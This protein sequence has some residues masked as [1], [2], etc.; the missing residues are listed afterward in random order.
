MKNKLLALASG[1]PQPG[2]NGDGNASGANQEGVGLEAPP[3]VRPQMGTNAKP[4]YP[5]DHV[6]AMQVPRG[7]S[8]C[9]NCKYLAPD[10][11]NC[12]E[13]N[14]IRWNGGPQ[15]PAPADSYRSDWYMPNPAPGGENGFRQV[16]RPGQIGGMTKGSQPA[17]GG[18]NSPLQ[19]PGTGMNAPG[20]V[21]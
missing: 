10:G 15:L 11:A 4:T 12:T 5:P 18:S 9:A 1:R 3:N 20:S 14:F 6:P 17:G 21:G 2:S 19:A 7:G 16:S 8:M 13:Q